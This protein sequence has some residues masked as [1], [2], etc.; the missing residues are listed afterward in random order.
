M[1]K[2]NK[3][4][5]KIKL[6]QFFAKLFAVLLITIGILL[7]FTILFMPVGFFMIPIGIAI[8][9]FIPKYLNKVLNR[10]LRLLDFDSNQSNKY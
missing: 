2:K 1:N 9:E 4:I 7:V 3:I 8:F 5:L 6:T 10:K